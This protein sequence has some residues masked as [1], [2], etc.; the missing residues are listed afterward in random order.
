MINPYSF[1]LT[2]EPVHK[3]NIE[4]AAVP[5]FERLSERQMRYVMLV[6]WFGSPLRFM[7]LE[8][9]KH[10]AAV[11]AGYKFESDGTRLDKNARNVLAG[12]DLSIEA[13]RGVMQNI[14]YSSEGA[15]KGAIDNQ[16]DEI[17]NF[18]NKPDK[19]AVEMEKAVK[20]MTQLPAILETRKKIME[21]LNFRDT[22]F[23]MDVQ[24]A[25]KALRPRS[26]LEQLN[27]NL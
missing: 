7:R 1:K 25:A 10:R 9:R 22:E 21:L 19:T 4:F 11:M 15:I 16:I 13:A 17:V 24:D 3:D 18:F 23:V 5:E 2:K 20:M 27:Q 26:I 14:Q 6:D 12:K 8:D